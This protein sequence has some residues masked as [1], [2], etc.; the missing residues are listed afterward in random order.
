MSS[1]N[2]TPVRRALL[3]VSDKTNIAPLGQAL[4]KAGV[5]LVSTGGTA[6]ALRDAG[7]EVKDVSNLT[8]FPEMMDGRVKTL[9]PAVHG[10]IL[11]DRSKKSHTEDLEKAG[12]GPID[13]V[14]I[15]LYPF[16]QTVQG[17]GDYQTC[18]ENIDIG[19]PAMIRAAAKNHSGVTVLTDPED[20]DS[21]IE[22]LNQNNNQIPEK[23]R[24]T[25]AL[26]AFT[27]TAAYDAAIS[28]WLNEQQGHDFPNIMLPILKNGRTLRYGENP[29]QS[30]AVYSDGHGIA[31]ADV[32]QGKALSYNNYVDA[33]AAWGLVQEFKEPACVIVKHANP[34]GTAIAD[35]VNDA[36]TRALECD[37][38]CAFGGIVAV[39]NTISADL[40]KQ[41]TEIFLEVVIAPAVDDQAAR[42][43]REKQNL[44][45]LVVAD[46]PNTK[47]PP[48]LKIKSISGGVVVQQTDW[49]T[50]DASTL[51]IPTKR[52]PT[53]EELQDMKFAWD[54][55]KHV[56]SNAI[57]VAKEGRSLGV[58][59]GQMSRVDSAH[60]ALTK[61]SEMAFRMDQ[62]A[63]ALLKNAVAASDAFLPFPDTM[64]VLA[65][66]GVKALIQPGGSKNDET[67]IQAA[68]QLGVAMV[69]TGIRHF[70][71]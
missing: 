1:E 12:F 19:G 48:P 2:L 15:N 4:A 14:V 40:A 62:C 18:V 28:A 5:E 34:C 27:H 53:P 16:S 17:G 22:I 6:K 31:G 57:L 11:F 60:L 46:K 10:G 45:V 20:Y 64:E 26:K 50:L 65:E 32:L 67:V 56:K 30:A 21:F 23:T 71:H 24:K 37:P 13:V 29:H 47:A 44:R 33:D 54:V 36:Y 58:G 52:Q 55:A 8:G 9:H 7:L 66:R 68:D 25:M 51:T 41:L 59:A 3:S 70:N 49:N 61:A 43:L 42:I 39:N 35:N 69:F 38:K 63:D